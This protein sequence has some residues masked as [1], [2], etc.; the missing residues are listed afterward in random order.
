LKLSELPA[1]TK[2]L[3]I[4]YTAL[5]LTIPER[6]RFRYRLEG[7][8]QGWRDVGNRREA[9]YT[10]LGPGTYRFR[11]IACN[12]D[13]VWNE[14]GAVLD[15]TIAPTFYQTWWF[16]TLC[17][18]AGAGAIWLVYLLRVNQVALQFQMRLDDR[19]AERERIARE[20]H[21][22]LLQGVQGLMLHFDAA[23]KQLPP[24]GPARPLME[25][26]LHVADQV[27]LEGRERV[28][29]LRSAAMPLQEL[30]ILLARCGEELAEGSATTFKLAVVGS[31]RALDPIVLD[32]MYR[33]GREALL[34]AFR[35]SMASRIEIE[36][37]YD[38]AGLQLRIRDDGRG[39]DQETLESGMP[40]HW[41]L[42]GMRER[43]QKLGGQLGFWSRPGA[44]TEVDLTIPARLAYTRRLLPS[45]SYWL[46]RMV[47][48]RRNR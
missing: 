21:D 37:T 20:L 45:R 9:I 24:L 16:K 3:Q 2:D 15:F 12:N 29:G 47:A 6:I 7:Q 5:S 10:N 19:L 25:K 14:T 1:R 8:D 35:H 41:G 32:E 39:I 36:I 33:I 18:I 43:A 23:M 44:G 42:S 17:G 31:S 38:R 26:A 46:K 11:V 34:N 28:R 30:S 48:R 4:V 40:G 22:T 27:L 13:G